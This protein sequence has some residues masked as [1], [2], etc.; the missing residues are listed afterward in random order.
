MP[1]VVVGRVD[2]PPSWAAAVQSFGEW[3]PGYTLARAALAAQT[4]FRLRRRQGQCGTAGSSTAAARSGSR[5]AIG[6]KKATAHGCRRRIIPIHWSLRPAMPSPRSA[7][8]SSRPTGHAGGGACPA[9]RDHGALA[10]ARSLR[11]ERGWRGLAA[12]GE[13]YCAGAVAGRGAGAALRWLAARTETLGWSTKQEG[14]WEPV[15]VGD[16]LVVSAEAVAPSA[17]IAA[18]LVDRG[19]GSGGPDRRGGPPA[20]LSQGHGRW[21]RARV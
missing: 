17:R 1:K 3:N 12:A 15:G 13:R 19:P 21:L 16:Q 14:Y 7:R 9:D 6:P 4:R 5:P 18:L 2:D 10:A 8:R 20:A 11:W